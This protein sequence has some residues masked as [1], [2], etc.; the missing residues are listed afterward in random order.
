ML[1]AEHTNEGIPMEA[2]LS[3]RHRD[4]VEKIFSEPASHNIE[5]REV[6]SL[7]ETIGTVTQEHNGK[8][9]VSLGPETEVFSEP[10]GKD[11]EVQT[12]VDLRRMLKQA[13]FTPESPIA[14]QSSRDHGDGQWGEPT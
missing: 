13:G 10:H 9:K 6:V 12:V 3:S 8:L 14:D 2:H 1:S 4:T 7:L 11:I 5:W